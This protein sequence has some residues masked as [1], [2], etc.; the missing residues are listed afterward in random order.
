MEWSKIKN[1]I[2]LIL[3]GLN[4]ILLIIVGDQQYQSDQVARNTRFQVLQTLSR[5]GV[6]VSEEILPE[7]T[8]LPVLQVEGDPFLSINAQ[9][10]L[11]PCTQNEST[12]ARA[13]Y[14][15]ARGTAELYSSGRFLVQ[16]NAGLRTASPGEEAAAGQEALE[17]LGLTVRMLEQREENG[18]V[19]VTYCQLWED[20]PI[21]DAL[22]AAVFEDGELLSLSGQRVSGTASTLE[23]WRL[24]DVPTTLIQFLNWKNEERLVFSSITSMEAG[25]Q[26]SNGRTALLTPVWCITTETGCYTVDTIGN[27]E[28]LSLGS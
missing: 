19:T 10:L 4:L 1:I 8:T 25:Y 21:F 13:V 2:L 15:S 16:A 24:T 7:N 6:S 18:L 12:D 14:S 23:V 27:V 22:C 28:A 17:Q 26:F 3:L 5:N 20:V 9:A 11:G